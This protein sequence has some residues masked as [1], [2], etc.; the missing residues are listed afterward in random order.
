[1]KQAAKLETQ[2]IDMR[3]GGGG[4]EERKREG[5][6]GLEMKRC[7]KFVAPS[8][9]QYVLWGFKVQRGYWSG[10]ILSLLSSTFTF[11]FYEVLTFVSVLMYPSILLSLFFPCLSFSLFFGCVCVWHDSTVRV[12]QRHKHLYMHTNIHIHRHTES[13]RLP[14]PL[15]LTLRFAASPTCCSE[16]VGPKL[17]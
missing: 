2:P 5:G 14:L 4:E 15:T 10:A 9:Y 11:F 17:F 13:H 6:R 3:G 16:R 12:T 1:M 8:V 7:S